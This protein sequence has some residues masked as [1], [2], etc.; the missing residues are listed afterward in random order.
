[1]VVTVS[2]HQIRDE[3][4]AWLSPLNISFSVNWCHLNQETDRNA[5]WRRSARLDPV[6][7]G[8]RF[9]ID[10]KD[11]ADQFMFLLKFGEHV[12]S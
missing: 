9:G 10:F 11:D 7:T 6:Q 1:M 12:K 3:I 4:A 5:V 2:S 8:W